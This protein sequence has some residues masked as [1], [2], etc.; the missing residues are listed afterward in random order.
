[1]DEAVAVAIVA[2][3]LRIA[4]LVAI[5]EVADLRRARV[6][7][8]VLVVAVVTAAVDRVVTVAVEIGG[9]AARALLGGLLAA[10]ARARRAALDAPARVGVARARIA[11]LDAVAEDAVVALGRAR[12]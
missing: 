9:V 5:V 2:E 7:L 12:A 8:D 1:R 11:R 10:H 4:V 3:R 6:A